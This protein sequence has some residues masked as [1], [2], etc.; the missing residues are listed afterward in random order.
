VIHDGSF[1]K[2][3]DNRLDDRVSIP[4]K[5]KYFWSKLNYKGYRAYYPVN[6]VGFF[7]VE[8]KLDPETGHLLLSRARLHY[9]FSVHLFI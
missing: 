1:G 6:T 2:V 5:D 7:T 4:A 9:R 3:D 8:K